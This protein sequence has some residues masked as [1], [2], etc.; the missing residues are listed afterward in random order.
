[1]QNWETDVLDGRQG[2]ELSCYGMKFRK[3]KGELK[4]KCSTIK[5]RKK[6]GEKEIELG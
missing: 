6:D 3:G 1:M 2:F 5:S 4:R